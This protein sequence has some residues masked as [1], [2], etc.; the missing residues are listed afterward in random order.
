MV[1]I[2]L[3][4]ADVTTCSAGD[5]NNDKQVTVDEIVSA[6]YNALNGCPPTI[7]TPSP[8]PT[9]TA[10]PLPSAATPTPTA[11]AGAQTSPGP[12]SA[13]SGQSVVAMNA[14]S[15]FAHV[16]S[17]IANGVTIGGAASTASSTA[18][19][20]P[21]ADPGPGGAAG[22]CPLGGSATRTGSLFTGYT[23]TFQ[24]NCAVQTVD[25]KVTFGGSPISIG[26][27]G[28]SA[29]L[30]TMRF[31]DIGGAPVFEDATASLTGTLVGFPTQGGSCF[32]TAIAFNLTGSL[33]T[34]MTPPSGPH[35][36]VTFAGTTLSVSNVTFS[37]VC[38][39]TAYDLTLDG[40]ATLL[41]PDGST[42]SVN[43]SN[44]T[45]HISSS[46]SGTT[47]TITNGGIASP[48]F[49]STGTVTAMLLTTTPLL[50]PIHQIC[51]TAGVITA[52]L[53]QPQGT[54][55]ITFGEGGSV[56]IQSPTE[57]LNAPNCLDPKLLAC[58]A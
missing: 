38:V 15:V 57:N 22:A 40:P 14:V 36:R 3:G 10:T 41:A 48:C 56:Q 26:L 27:S 49:S 42:E 29:P 58:V 35:V 19:L 32:V 55:T 50:V 39:P 13:V 9:P 53:P 7:V 11:T 43:F 5:P 18:L 52:T 25:G 20:M 4:G 2:A 54:A 8:S 6:V 16:V 37:S 34:T 21:P 45:L 31:S 30:V 1:N 51:P 23:I 28:L 44:L 33:E 24:D 47:V 17:A 46:A 12:G